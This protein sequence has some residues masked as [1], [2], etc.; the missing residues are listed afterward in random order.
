MR[1]FENLDKLSAGRA[2]PHTAPIPGTSLNLD[3]S[4]A[5]PVGRKLLTNGLD[6]ALRC[7]TGAD[8]GWTF[9]TG[10]KLCC[11]TYSVIVYNL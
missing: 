11:S 6:L 5:S 10:H 7:Q 8:E 2:P 1:L 3:H 4:Q 9:V